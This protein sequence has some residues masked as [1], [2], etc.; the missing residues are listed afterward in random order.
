MPRPFPHASTAV[1]RDRPHLQPLSSS[2]VIRFGQLCPRVYEVGEKLDELQ[3]RVA[4]LVASKDAP[5]VGYQVNQLQSEVAELRDTL[6]GYLRETTR[7][8]LQ[9]IYPDKIRLVEADLAY[10][11]ADGMGDEQIL[12]SFCT[13]FVGVV[14][15]SGVAAVLR[16]RK[17]TTSRVWRGFPRKNEGECGSLFFYEPLAWA[18]RS[19]VSGYLL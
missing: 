17:S 12:W 6:E 1:S 2:G 3:E 11:L 10:R 19:S 4:E 5:S 18:R 16:V 7:L 15:S 9:L 14:V 8:T 13:L